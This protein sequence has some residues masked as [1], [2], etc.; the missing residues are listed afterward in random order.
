MTE[1][2]SHGPI[3]RNPRVLF[4]LM[5]CAYLSMPAMTCAK[6]LAA[7]TVHRHMPCSAVPDVLCKDS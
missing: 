4:G 2:E 3:A 7:N 5:V 1:L 6:C